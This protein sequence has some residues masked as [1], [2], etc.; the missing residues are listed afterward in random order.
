MVDIVLSSWV[1]EHITEK[2]IE[3]TTRALAQITAPDGVHLHFIDMRDHFF[4]YPFQMLTFS[5][6]IW[7]RCFNPPSNLNRWRL[8]DYRQIFEKYF[9]EV[10]IHVVAREPE[11]FRKALP[12]I[13]PEFLTGDESID[14]ITLFALIARSPR[15]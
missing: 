15:R 10:N 4:K 14:A 5:K 11:K 8:K 6:T 1:Y 12:H 2:E 9:D 7:Q 3:P 13:R